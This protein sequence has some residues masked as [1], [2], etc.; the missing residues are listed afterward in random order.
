MRL[1]PVHIHEALREIPEEAHHSA[2]SGL[3]GE[4][5][6]TGRMEG[7]LRFRS[8]LTLEFITEFLDGHLEFL[9]ERAAH[10]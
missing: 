4:E 9:S 2:V 5:S 1:L 10:P 7:L 6:G 3:G 8:V